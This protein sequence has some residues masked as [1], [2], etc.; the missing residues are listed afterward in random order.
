MPRRWCFTGNK[1]QD[2]TYYWHTGYPGGIKE[3]KARQMLDGTFPR[4]GARGGGA[5]ACCRAVRSAAQ[6]LTNLRVYKGPSHP[7]EAQQPEALDVACTEP[8]EFAERLI[9]G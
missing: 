1:R 5:S 2:K 7:H 6:Q 8:Q 9:H 4:A 3:R